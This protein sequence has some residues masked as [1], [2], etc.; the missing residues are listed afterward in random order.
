MLDC[1]QVFIL[2]PRNQPNRQFKTP[3]CINQTF[4]PHRRAK[5]C[6]I[7]EI[8]FAVLKQIRR[9]SPRAT[10]HISAVSNIFCCFIGQR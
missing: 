5:T 1:Y 10:A 4:T 2:G 3:A 9:R 8:H 6:F 7:S